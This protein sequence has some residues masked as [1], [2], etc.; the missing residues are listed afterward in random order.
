[1]GGRR[2][3]RISSWT[4]GLVSWLRKHFV[5]SAFAILNFFLPPERAGSVVWRASFGGGFGWWALGS[6]V[7]P[8][9]EIASMKNAKL[10][11]EIGRT[12]DRDVSCKLVT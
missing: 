2:E 5:T 12:R 4:K 10:G 3:E 7:L 11:L 6:V 8:M 1:L 9:A